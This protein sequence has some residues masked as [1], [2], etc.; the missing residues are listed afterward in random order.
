MG[1]ISK[2]IF[3]SFMIILNDVGIKLYAGG[4]HDREGLSFINGAMLVGLI[5]TFGI[6][7]FSILK[8]K[9]QSINHRIIAISILPILEFIPINC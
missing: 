7:L 9:K 4:A 6:L 2:S 3:L 1:C 5:P 8:R